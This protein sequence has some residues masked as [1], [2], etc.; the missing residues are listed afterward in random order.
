MHE[1]SAAE[2]IE[3]VGVV[4]FT[5]AME[6]HGAVGVAFETVGCPTGCE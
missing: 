6:F 3:N 2:R 1:V 5:V 4:S